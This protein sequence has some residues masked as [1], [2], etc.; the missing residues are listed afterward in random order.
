MLFLAPDP[1]RFAELQQGVRQYLAWKSIHEERE[2]LNLDAYQANQAKSKVESADETVR[3]R[4][5][6]THAWLLVPTQ[7]DAMARVEWEES[8]LQGDEPIVMRASRKARAEEYLVTQYGPTNLAA[9][10]KRIPLW[11]P[12]QDHVAV[13]AL[14]GYCTQYLYLQ[15]VRDASII[16]EAIRDGVARLTW[17]TETFAYAEGWD[18][19]NGRYLGLRTSATGA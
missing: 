15:R 17:E 14:T 10:I 7:S 5:P 4:I 3:R 16:L 18:E 1:T 13:K 19:D 6:E 2:T 12:G 8:R 9:D 11:P